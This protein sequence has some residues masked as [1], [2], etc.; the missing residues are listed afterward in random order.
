MKLVKEALGDVLRGPDLDPGFKI[1]I[2]SHE[3]DDLEEFIS[4]GMENLLEEGYSIEDATQ[5]VEN[6]LASK[7]IKNMIVEKGKYWANFY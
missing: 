1:L 2:T 5:T 4:R 7:D 3:F 6:F